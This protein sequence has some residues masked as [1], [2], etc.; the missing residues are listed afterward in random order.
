VYFLGGCG[1]C[2]VWFLVSVYFVYASLDEG[3]VVSTTGYQG[4]F[5]VPHCAGE[6]CAFYLVPRNVFSASL[7][8]TLL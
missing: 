7:A 8:G 4:A 1:K 5:Y 2:Y 3:G 6:C